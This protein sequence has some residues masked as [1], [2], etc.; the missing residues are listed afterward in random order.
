ME[1]CVERCVE[2]CG[3]MECKCGEGGREGGKTEFG[4]WIRLD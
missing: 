1:R 3:G 4:A 2:I